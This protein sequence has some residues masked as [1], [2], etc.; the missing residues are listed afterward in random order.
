VRRL[1]RGDLVRIRLAGSSDEWVKGLVWVVS[2]TNPSS[3]G[4]MIEG[5]VR[6]SGG[7]WIGGGL[8]LLVDYDA[9]TVK[10]LIGDEYEIG[11]AE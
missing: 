3:V 5:M 8:P 1:R 10:S 7:G 9:G 11:V 6:S 4:L 2:D